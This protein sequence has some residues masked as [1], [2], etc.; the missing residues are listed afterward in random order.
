MI[1]EVGTHV[2]NIHHGAEGVVTK[3]I[4]SWDDGRGNKGTYIP[5]LVEVELGA[6]WITGGNEG[7][8]VYPADH[9]E[10]IE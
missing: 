6:A 1:I 10:V 8:G 4:T 9:L 5:M 7:Y 2:R 3:L